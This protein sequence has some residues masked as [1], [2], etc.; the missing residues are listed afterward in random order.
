[1]ANKIQLRRGVK[2]NLPTLSVGEPA[3]C[4]DTNQFFV[5]TGSSNVEYAKQSSVDSLNTSLNDLAND[6]INKN[7]VSNSCSITESGF[8]LDARQGKYLEDLIKSINGTSSYVTDL[9]KV[10]SMIIKYNA[11]TLNTPYT[12]GLITAG[13]GTCLNFMDGEVQIA[14]PYMNNSIFMRYA[15]G[16][17]VKVSA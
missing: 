16:T 15:K 8:V 11:S 13:I 4:T 14:F 9:N 6:K 17:W 3:F 12:Q 2:A 1:M 10:N 7:S 5:G